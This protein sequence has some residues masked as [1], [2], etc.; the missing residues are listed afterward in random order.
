MITKKEGQFSRLLRVAFAFCVAALAV[1]SL[2]PAPYLTRTTLGGHVEH[3]IAYLGT[4]VVMG[5]AFQ[6]GPRLEIQCALLI[7]YAAVLEALQVYSPGRHSSIFD[8]AFSASGIIAGG[9]AL[10]ALARVRPPQS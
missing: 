3:V 8:L 5:L 2:L 6:R 1:L 9:L 7:L 10:W 4:A